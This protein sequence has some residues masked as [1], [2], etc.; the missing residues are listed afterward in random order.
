MKF[1]FNIQPIYIEADSEKEARDKFIDYDGLI[2]FTDV[3][4][5]GGND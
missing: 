4:C 2:E 5:L 1:K 3:E